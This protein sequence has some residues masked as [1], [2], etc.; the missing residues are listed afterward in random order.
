[1]QLRPR[2]FVRRYNNPQAAAEPQTGI[3]VKGRGKGASECADRE[4][5]GGVFTIPLLYHIPPPVSRGFAEKPRT[6]RGSSPSVPPF[7]VKNAPEELADEFE[8]ENREGDEHGDKQLAAGQ[9]HGA[10]NRA[11]EVD[12]QKLNG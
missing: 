6:A 12:E 5:R 10:E 8:R 9:R 2:F 3:F 7:A 1:M 4:L 11:A